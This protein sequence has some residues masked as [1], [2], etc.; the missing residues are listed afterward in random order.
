M[1]QRILLKS[2]A[3]SDQAVARAAAQKMAA[4]E[5]AAA[6]GPFV[7]RLHALAYAGGSNT[8]SLED[9]DAEIAEAEQEVS[10][11]EA[12]V[13]TATEYVQ[14]ACSAISTIVPGSQ[15]FEERQLAALNC[16]NRAREN[17]RAAREA[18]AAAK[19]RCQTLR[20]RRDA[21][22]AEPERS[23][24]LAAGDRLYS[25]PA[26]SQFGE[27]EVWASF[28]YGDLCSPGQP[29][30][31]FCGRPRVPP[32][33]SLPA[34]LVVPAFGRFHDEARRAFKE[35]SRMKSG[36]IRVERPC[37]QR[38]CSGSP[39]PSQFSARRMELADC[40]FVRELQDDMLRAPTDEAG[41]K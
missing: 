32:P 31:L 2:D 20:S 39:G 7:A 29:P 26:P 10:E 16:V 21:L 1:P 36:A 35:I 14:A 18:L 5:G 24:Q 11:G 3:P 27:P 4:A 37:R 41:I 15:L 25:L 6:T 9:L 38:L 17:L 33:V 30:P 28:Q 13:K 12:A 40:N 23:T 8:E 34:S 19:G 22:A